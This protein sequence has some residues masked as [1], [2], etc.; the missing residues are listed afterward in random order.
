M[1]GLMIAGRRTAS[2]EATFL[3]FLLD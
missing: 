3:V 1:S 2:N